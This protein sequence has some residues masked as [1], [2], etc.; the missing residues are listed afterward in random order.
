MM[1]VI[2]DV[3][4]AATGTAAECKAAT[5][6]KQKKIY[7]SEASKQEKVVGKK[8]NNIFKCFLSTPLAL[9]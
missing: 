2:I 1:R 7:A 9:P 4:V 5:K 6:K 8:S 3:V